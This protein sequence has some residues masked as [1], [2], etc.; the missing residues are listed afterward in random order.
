MNIGDAF[1]LAFGNL[2][3]RRLRSWLTLLGIFA[4]IAAIVA[5]ISLGQGL[6]GAV[7]SQF[8]SLGVNTLSVQG[9]GSNY[10]P[11][12]TNAVGVIDDHDVRLLEDVPDVEMA[13][14]RYIQAT[15]IEWRII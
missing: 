13:I 9:A 1:K 2:I 5:L 3:H 7:N 6:Q 15:T 4:G 14:G 10:G 11:P 8:G 12:G